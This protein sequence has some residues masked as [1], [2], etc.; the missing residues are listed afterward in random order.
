MNTYTRLTYNKICKIKKVEFI[1]EQLLFVFKRLY[2]NKKIT[3]DEYNK[4]V[5]IIIKQYS[6]T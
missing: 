6:N 5:S 2:D 3:I 4:A 1:R